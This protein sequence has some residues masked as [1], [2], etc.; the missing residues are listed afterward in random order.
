VVPGPPREVSVGTVGGTI[1]HLPVVRCPAGHQEPVT[2]EARFGRE[3]LAA[4][5]RS[6]LHT[7][8]RLLGGEVCGACGARLT[9]PV[10]RS[11]WPV[12]VADVAGLPVLTLRFD[13][14]ST[15]CPDCGVD[16]LPRRSHDDLATA[17]GEL[18]VREDRR[19]HDR[20]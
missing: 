1:A 17:V 7:R 5:R 9:M 16:Q 14:P 13:L 4:V 12:T 11:E 2:D 20:P 19:R 8:A 3:V 15:R 10:R 18:C 6:V